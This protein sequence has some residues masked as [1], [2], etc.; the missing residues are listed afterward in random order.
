MD[1]ATRDR[2]VPRRHDR[3]PDM[4]VTNRTLLSVSL[5]A[6]LALGACGEDPAKVDNL[7]LKVTSE[8]PTGGGKLDS[9]RILFSKNGKHFPADATEAAFNP[10]LGGEDPTAGPVHIS[11]K[12][13]GQTFDSPTGVTLLVTGRVAGK[14]VTAS[15][16]VVDLGKDVILPVRLTRVASEC[17]LDSD[18]FLDCDVTGCCATGRVLDDCEPSVAGANPWGVENTCEDADDIDNDC[19]GSDVTPPNDDGDPVVDCKETACGADAGRADV[20]PAVGAAAGAPELCD[21]RDNDCDG[22]TD[23]GLVLETPGDDLAL[24]A[25]CGVGKCAGGVVQCDGAGGVECSTAE[26]ANATEGCDGADE[27][28]DDDCDGTTDEGCGPDLV[29]VDGDGVPNTTDCDDFDG[30]RYPGNLA[31]EGCCDPAAANNAALRAACDL[32]CDD[33][34]IF[35]CEE[36]DEDGDGF[37]VAEG[38]CDDDPS[39]DQAT[40]PARL[41]YPGA[42]E[43]CGDDVDQDC[44]DG[45]LACAGITDGDNDDWPAG[46]DCDDFDDKIAPDAP[47]RCNAK[48][49][50]CDGL[51]DEDN[52]TGGGACGTDAG[53]CSVG[54][55]VCTRAL[56][57]GETC[58]NGG[59]APCLVCPNDVEG[60]EETCN[61]KDDDCDGDTDDGFAYKG[62]AVGESCDGEGACGQGTVECLSDETAQPACSTNP[63]GSASQAT[64]EVCDTLDNDCDGDTNEGLTD[65][66][67]SDCDRDGVCGDNLQ[68]VQAT[69]LPAGG[70]SCNYANVPG[71]Q[72]NAETLCDGKDNDCDGGT[73][74]DITLVDAQGAT[75][76]VG[77]GCDG[78]DADQCANGM[79][80]CDPTDTSKAY[81]DETNA[82]T[83]PE[84]CDGIDNDC[85]GD[86]DEDFTRGPDQ[87]PTKALAGALYASDNGKYKNETCGTGS[88]GTGSVVCSPTDPTRLACVT[89]IAPAQD[90][91]D[92]FDNDCDGTVDEAFIAGGTVTYNGGPYTDNPN[93]PAPNDGDQGKVK[94]SSCGTGACAG[95][96]VVCDGLDAL[97]CSTVPGTLPTDVCD[98][99]DNDCDGT[100]DDNFLATAPSASKVT[101]QGALA[102]VDNGKSKDAPCGVGEC[103]GGTVECNG[104]G[105]GLA[106]STDVEAQTETCEGKDDSCDGTTDEG[107]ADLD[108]DGEAN[109]VDGDDDGDGKLDGADDCPAGQTGWTSNGTTDYDGDGC[110]DDHAEDGDDDDDGVADGSDACPKGNLGWTSSVTTDHDG[111]GCQDTPTAD[112]EDPDEDNDGVLDEVDDCRQGDTGWTA[113]KGTTGAPGTD[114]DA[115][116]C[117]DAGEDTDDDDDGKPDTTDLCDPDNT[118]TGDLGANGSTIGWTRTVG[119]TGAPGTDWD[120]DGCQDSGEDLDDDNDLKPD[121][122]DRC[123]PDAGTA[124]DGVLGSAKGWTRVAGATTGAGADYDDD[125]CRDSDEDNDDDND[126]K[127]DATDRCDPDNP[128]PI[129]D[130][131]G[132]TASAIGWA[133]AVGATTGADADFDDD[134]CRDSSE[135]LDDDNDSKA[136][137]GDLCDPDNPTPA[138]GDLGV[139]TSQVFWARN[140]GASSGVNADYDDDGCRDSDED[141]DDDNDGKNDDVDRCDPDATGDTGSVGSNTGWTSSVGTAQ[142]LGTDWDDD[143]CRDAGE[144]LDDDNDG[145][146]DDPDRCDPDASGTGDT[147]AVGSA[148]GWVREIGTAQAPLSDWDDDGCR[149]SDED[150]DDDNDGKLDTADLCDPDASGPAG[151]TGIKGSSKGW[152]RVVGQAGVADADLDDDGC[153]D[154]DEDVD[155]DN[156][157]KNDDVDR[158]DPDASGPS[159]DT[160]AV[161]SNTGWTSSVGTA[162]ALGTDWDDDG[163]RDAGEDVDDDNDGKLDGDDR[164]DPDAS[165]PTG[166][167]G[168]VGSIKG[169]TRVVSHTGAD[170]DWD[171]DGCRDSD[172]DGD[173]DNDGKSDATDR[174][175]PDASGPAEDTGAAASSKTWTSTVG[176]APSSPGTDWDDDGCEDAAAED[177]DDDNDGKLDTTD[178][179]DPD[180]AGGTDLGVNASAKGWSRV[181]G[182]PEAPGSDWDDDGCRDSDEDADDDNDG[183][184]DDG[185]L[186]DPDAGVPTGDTGAIGSTKGW[187]RDV[188]AS[189]GANADYDDDGCQDSGE[190]TDDDNDAVADGGDACDPESGD[191]SALGPFDD[192]DGDG[193][194]DDG[195]D[196]DD[197][198]DGV[199]DDLD[200][201][202]PDSGLL[203]SALGPFTDNDADGCRD[204]DEDPDDD[205]DTVLDE[206]GAAACNTGQTSGCDDNCPLV[207]NLSQTDTDDDGLGDACDGDDDGDG[208]LDGVDKCPLVADPGQLDGDGDGDGDACDN[209]VAVSNADQANA[210]G[211]ATGDACDTCTDAD[212]DGWGRASLTRSS[213]ANGST[214]DCDDALGNGSDPDLDNVCTAGGAS[215]CATGQT[216]GCK[217][218]CPAV[219]NFD[220]SDLDRDTKGDACDTCVYGKAP[221]EVCGDCIDNDCDGSTDEVEC[222]TRR[223]VLL[224]NGAEALPADYTVSLRFD[225]AQLVD[226]GLSSA[227]GNDVRVFLKSPTAACSDTDASACYTELDRIADPGEGLGFDQTTTTIWFRTGI[228]VAANEISTN[229][230]IFF[231]TAGTAPSDPA[232]VFYFSDLFD[233][234]LSPDWSTAVSAG[235]TVTMT[236]GELLF[237]TTA[238]NG[239]NGQNNPAAWRTIP[240]IDGSGSTKAWNVRFGFD[241]TT[242][243]NDNT[244]RLAMQLLGSSAADP[245]TNSDNLATTGVGPTVLWGAGTTGNVIF[246]AQESFG[247]FTSAGSFSRIGTNETVTTGPLDVALHV[248]FDGTP[249]FDV[250][251]GS[252]SA[253]GRA[254]TA[255][256]VPTSLTKVRLMG[257]RMTQSAFSKRAFDY[258]LIRRATLSAANDPLLY[259]GTKEPIGD[260]ASCE[261][262]DAS[263]L[264]QYYLDDPTAMTPNPLTVADAA[265]SPLDLERVPDGVKGPDFTTVSGLGALVFNEALSDGYVGDSI[266]GTKFLTGANALQGKGAATFEFV[267][268][269]AVT[270]AQTVYILD[271]DQDDFAIRL[272]GPST[273]Q[274]MLEGSGTPIGTWTVPMVDAQR[275]VLHLVLDFASANASDATAQDDK[276][277]L[278]YN[279]LLLTPATQTLAS[280]TQ[281]SFD[282][283]AW[284]TIG[285][286]FFEDSSWYGFIYYAGIYG[287]A[288]DKSG[289]SYDATLIKKHAT[290]LLKD[291]DMR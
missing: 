211:D 100:T 41:V 177:T 128:A 289:A 166:D 99:V 97:R 103:T 14:V 65:V 228:A 283:Q 73:D 31:V 7:F 258:V 272:S 207:A 227:N 245:V 145:K 29:D 138:N 158:C 287:R 21:S 57:D 72:A 40:F 45:D 139:T 275:A 197:D 63:N 90:R 135:D 192:H 30:G 112:D 223:V 201:C 80:T 184:S 109:C 24:G 270:S 48:D 11:V 156:D 159:G 20:Y 230:E 276:T 108:E 121:T 231:G 170:A 202:D 110:R 88:C 218:N 133:R 290:I 219:Q 15:E 122:T 161:A 239:G 144:D 6:A 42:G 253:T 107:F 56:P 118:G 222:S 241:W 52:P 232:D 282:A 203:T 4:F 226:A 163:C 183:K 46:A 75:R 185:D 123:D 120:D 171:D 91:C 147:G 233:G 186:C 54:T 264:A 79:T 181:V 101:L 284:L 2:E 131:L 255:A 39:D 179:C 249:S 267:L 268:E 206:G 160:G 261:L 165:T 37:T 94:G 13:N 143:G 154:S 167:S 38:D 169:W 238:D 162:E 47:E 246:P 237:A 176:S 286:D 49:D 164:C 220:Q 208:V 235:N 142:A 234:S 12:Y 19:S 214:E 257:G 51:T 58:M 130:D 174:C 124:P 8:A 114:W 115:D 44:Q 125:G 10:P 83:A 256:T 105:T 69:C 288:L 252:V 61:D 254:F 81:C 266:E 225:H 149:D 33:N 221:Y 77:E 23:E 53:E 111:D 34:N 86:T 247:T 215:F 262:T 74:E 190:D 43:K 269:S 119:T 152:T 178:R 28:V 182:A 191:E 36:G 129:G 280:N 60:T 25:G 175:D 212:N 95:G 137:T 18:G 213:C 134:G 87:D 281:L 127:L 89:P 68:L 194:D 27:D 240:T 210:D 236:G 168:A 16:T 278:Y 196:D 204:S 113:S 82:T 259:L 35:F 217:D 251:F 172:E 243:G 92:G 198:K 140:V 26:L 291:D 76:K 136:D 199:A 248:E 265:S 279:G 1:E 263:L 141:P 116:G 195:E 104:A 188:G 277:R 70:W 62:V 117:R 216:T 106:C 193:C 209:C 285:N 102:A 93:T 157:G 180:N 205:N 151:D 153:R 200:P 244:Y 67:D 273:I 5:A 85:D 148:T 187:T 78:A 271:V 242:N 229:H 17:D 55:S 274:V 260:S 146:L 3:E 132:V 250:T 50:D 155:D 84:T 98:D 96:T 22:S 59:Q 224:D 71:Y 150:T 66:D 64:D 32:D 9:L 189:V 126:G 173:D